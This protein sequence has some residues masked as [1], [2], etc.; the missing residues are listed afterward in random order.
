M[1]V[2]NKLSPLERSII[3]Q[4]LG[5][6]IDKTRGRV[7]TRNIDYND[8]NPDL[9]VDLT[10]G[11]IKD[12]GDSYYDGDFIDFVGKV[13][14]KSFIEVVRYCESITG[15]KLLD[16]NMEGNGMEAMDALYSDNIDKE[17]IPAKEEQREFWDSDKKKALLKCIEVLKKRGIPEK[18]EYIETYDGIDK[19]TLLKFGCGIY[20]F[21]DFDFGLSRNDYSHDIFFVFPYRTGAMLYRRGENGKVIRHIKGSISKGSFFGVPKPIKKSSILFIQKSPRECMSF[22]R[23]VYGLNANVIGIAT[24]EE[25]IEITKT[26]KD[27][28][29]SILRDNGSCVYVTTD[30]DNPKSYEKTLVFCK[31]LSDS[32]GDIATVHLVNIHKEFKGKMKDFTDIVQKSE[33]SGVIGLAENGFFQLKE[34]ISKQLTTAIEKSEAIK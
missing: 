22:T 32:I 10:N 12:F 15:K 26:Q 9:V 34:D 19:E 24:G 8:T 33:K 7:R 14:K 21:K 28:L 3:L 18:M 13:T 29:V 2:N 16:G 20:G 25:V 30:C 31:V 23:F 1:S 4:K 27:Q 11:L 17:S 6:R 5:F